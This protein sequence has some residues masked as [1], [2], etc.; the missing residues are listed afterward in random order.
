MAQCYAFSGKNQAETFDDVITGT[1]LVCDRMANMLFDPGSTFS[2][3]SVRFTS[4]FDIICDICDAPI[5]VSTPVGESVI[6]THVYRACPILFMGFQTWADLVMLDMTYFDIILGMTWLSPYYVVLNCNTKSITLEIPG[7]KKLEWEGVYKPKQAKIILFIQARKLV[8][9]GCLSYLAHIRNVD[10]EA[11]SIESIHVVSEFRE[12]FLNDLHGMPPNRDIDFCIDLEPGTCPISILPYRMAPAKLREL[13]S[14][15]QKLH[16]KR[17]IRPSV[18]PWVLQFFLLRKR[19]LKIRPGDVPK[20]AFRTR[21]G[22]YE[23]LVMS[24]GL[25]NAPAAFMGLMNEVFKQFLDSLV[26]VF[27]DDILVYLKSEEEHTD[28]L[29]I[30]LGVFGK[31]KLYEKFS[32]C[33]FWL[34]SVAFLGHVVSKEGVMVDPQK[35]EAVKNWVRPSSMTEVRI[36]VGL[37]SYYRRFM[38]NFASIATHLT[39]NETP[40]DWT[41]KCEESFQRLK[42]LLTTA[43]ILALPVEAVVFTL[44]IWWHYLYDVKCEVFTDHHNFQH[45]F[46][47]NDLNLRQRRWMELL[48]DYDV[49]IQYHPDKANVV[50]NALS[51]KTVNMV[52]YLKKRWVLVSIEVRA[53]FIDKIKAKQFEDENLEDLRKKTVIGKAQETTLDA[54]GVLNFKGIL[55]RV[56]DLIEK[57]LAESHGS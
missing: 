22:H 49:T 57:L 44:K 2:Y 11:P 18:S 26:I 50:A 8:E 23:F 48:K 45:V 43:S 30:V 17:F 14:Q 13:K 4:K 46:T 7:R 55:S 27:I 40:F 47:Q 52:G 33:E 34:T 25:T 28:H 32:K 6:V 9:Q 56:D 10:F 5:H 24:F 20:M 35:I 53:T 42:T 41:E 21:Y 38:K 36:F 15:I 54:D 31:Q 12:V 1:I 39:K 29:R 3:V 19:M 37:T 16:D 51:R